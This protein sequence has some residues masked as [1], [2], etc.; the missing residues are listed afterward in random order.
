ISLVAPDEEK[1][2]KSIERMTKQKIP[3]GDLM[4]FDASAVE[5]E[6][7]EAREPRQPRNVGQKKQKAEGGDKPKG[8]RHG[9]GRK[10]K[11]KDSGK[12]HKAEPQGQKRRGQSQRSNA[13]GSAAA[14]TPP[15]PPDRDPEEF[16]DDEIDNFGNRVDYVSPNQN[17]QQGRGRRSGAE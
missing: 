14:A 17:K 3:D 6:R 8:E 12:E 2:L 16:L 5:A 1:L 7:P 4:G 15:L 9:G 10:D 11:G 13:Q